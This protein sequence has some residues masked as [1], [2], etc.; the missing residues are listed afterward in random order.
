MGKTVT[1]AGT[2]H[3]NETELD[4]DTVDGKVLR[5][6]RPAA[7]GRG[8]K[9]F[10]KAHPGNGH[11]RAGAPGQTKDKAHPDASEGPGR[12]GGARGA[13]SDRLARSVSQFDAPSPAQDLALDAHAAPA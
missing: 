9:G 7:V 8:P 2:H 12:V 11:G 10:G 1:V 5:D 6:A 3:A 13:R 4:V